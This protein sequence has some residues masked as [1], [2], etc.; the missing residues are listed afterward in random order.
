MDTMKFKALLQG[1]FLA[2][3]QKNRMALL[4]A[5]IVLAMFIL[6]VLAPFLAGDPGAINIAHR[7]QPPSL[8]YPLGT[9]DLGRDVLA[10]ILYGARISLLVGFVA[11]GIAT[12][13]GIVLGALSGYYGGWVDGLTM[14]F[15]DIML[16]FPSFFLILAVIAFLEPS[17]WNIMIIIGLTGWMGVARLV[18]AEFLSLRERDFVVAARALGASDGRLI[19]RHI[20]PNA[21]SPIL[22]SATL[23]VAGAILTESALSFLGIGVQPP[24]P[25]WGN[26]LIAGKQTLGTAWW[27][28]AFPGLAILVTVLGYNLL[29]EGIRD[30]LDPR[31]KE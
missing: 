19:F 18:R 25:S 30:A 10:R 14:R 4:G 26:M 9:D 31:L 24:T 5:V 29:G 12:S 17:I 11:V 23:G 13:I 16:C 20:L 27:L 3:L 8:A 6:A 7:L 2:R 22:V 15:V 1:V 28:S 21:L